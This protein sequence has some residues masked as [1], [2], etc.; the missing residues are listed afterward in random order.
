VNLELNI[1]VKSSNEEHERCPACN[2]ALDDQ[3]LVAC[4]ADHMRIH[5]ACFN[6]GLVA[7]C[8]SAGC[9]SP[10]FPRA[11]E[12]ERG[13]S[14]TQKHGILCAGCQA[15]IRQRERLVS[16]RRQHL[17]VH[18]GCHFRRLV[19]FCPAPACGEPLTEQRLPPQLRGLLKSESRASEPES[20]SRERDE[21]RPTR[22]LNRLV[23][24]EVLR[25]ESPAQLSNMSVKLLVLLLFA[26]SLFSV[27]AVTGVLSKRQSAATPD[28]P[29]LKKMLNE[30]DEDEFA[31]ALVA[32][33]HRSFLDPL[34]VDGLA[35][36]IQNRS[37]PMA[38]KALA[39]LEERQ[40]VDLMLWSKLVN[41]VTHPEMFRSCLSRLSI[42]LS[43]SGSA[44]APFYVRFEFNSSAFQTQTS[45]A[46]FAA[47][48][49]QACR[50]VIPLIE[51]IREFSSVRR[52]RVIQIIAERLLN[53]VNE[54]EAAHAVRAMREV[55]LQ[56]STEEF[57]SLEP[58]LIAILQAFPKTHLD[59]LALARAAKSPRS[60]QIRAIV[61]KALP[62][63]DSGEMRTTLADLQ[64]ASVH[65]RRLLLE[66]ILHSSGKWSFSEALELR[67]YCEDEQLEALGVWLASQYSSDSRPLLSQSISALPDAL[68]RSLQKNFLA[69]LPDP[70]AFHA[71]LLILSTETGAMNVLQSINDLGARDTELIIAALVDADP[72]LSK[73]AERL[74]QGRIQNN[75]S[76]LV[77]D[78]MLASRRDD[79]HRRGVQKVLRAILFSNKGRV[80]FMDALMFL[81]RSKGERMSPAQLATLIKP[82]ESSVLD[83]AEGAL[84]GP[85]VSGAVEVLSCCE[86]GVRRL[87]AAYAKGL[88]LE[89]LRILA[90][91]SSEGPFEKRMRALVD[92]ARK[93]LGVNERYR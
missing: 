22:P 72:R 48:P 44:A 83:Y 90:F 93:R 45:K 82:F 29:R 43:K 76:N 54:G 27:L 58:K 5:L 46:L 70:A 40:P 84:G 74:L 50:D 65:E 64:A 14:E 6:E 71:L 13:A 56:G 77:G 18:Q 21:A 49:A 36:V 39:L 73:G 32:L 75:D 23:S 52:A 7:V 81:R 59:V 87:E 2:E 30:G 33:Q 86:A 24:N 78:I 47:L 53:P 26:I 3:P 9:R 4:S 89:A 28:I 51:N 15:P 68:L 34:L 25:S 63:T 35:L 17:W 31:E 66:D 16:C 60:A 42:A 37:L 20:N 79:A 1:R 88:E 92:G 55:L 67:D 61:H 10:L 11:R 19:R 69:R 80:T 91:A 8:P 12:L 62:A 57:M 85:Q 41:Q 38:R